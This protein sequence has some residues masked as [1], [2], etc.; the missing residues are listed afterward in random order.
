MDLICQAG[1]EMNDKVNDT[2]ND[3]TSELLFNIFFYSAVVLIIVRVF[4]RNRGEDSDVMEWMI[5]GMVISAGIIKL[6]GRFLPKWFQNNKPS[7]EEWEEK[8]HGK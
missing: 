3:K 6:A 7:R 1:R 2:T 5:F 4:L 8:I